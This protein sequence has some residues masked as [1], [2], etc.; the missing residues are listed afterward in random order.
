MNYTFFY[1]NKSPFSNF[2][3]ARF[4]LYGQDFTSAEQAFMW[5]KAWLF[6]D[7]DVAKE[8][9]VAKTP[10]EA[11]KLGRKV[12]GFNETMW[13]AMRTRVMYMVIVAKF[14]QNAELWDKLSETIGTK[15]VEA[16]PKD[17]VWGIGLSEDNARKT[18]EEE[19][20]GQNLLGKMLTKYREDK[21]HGRVKIMS[22][23]S[24]LQV[25]VATMVV[26]KKACC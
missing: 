22:L 3:H 16:S 18:P 14:G 7:T 11:K 17:M 13:Q 26:N 24:I 8:I 12:G 23:E 15:M 5:C 6:G 1:G 2:H 9:L 10:I 19:W 4:T 25:G 20:R 21:I